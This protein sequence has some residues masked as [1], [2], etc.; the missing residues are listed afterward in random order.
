MKSRQ[1][2]AYD[3]ARVAQYAL[4]LQEQLALKE[5]AL[6]EKE[7]LLAEARSYIAELKRQLFGPKA[8][9]L[10][11]EQEEQLRQVAGNLKEQAQR[12]PPLSQE[13]LE[14]KLTPKDPEKLKRESRHRRH[15]LPS[16]QLEVQRVVLQPGNFVTDYNNDSSK[17]KL[18]P[19]LKLALS[20]KNGLSLER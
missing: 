12:P 10:S 3:P 18:P 2:L 11:A 6:A 16:V 4:E 9:K 1:E 17:Y 13:V 20:D 19:E 14:A 5:Q 15:S 7:Q 8:D